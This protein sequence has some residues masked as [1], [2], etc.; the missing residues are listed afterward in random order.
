M[1][2]VASAVSFA[3]V[4]NVA[5]AG[6]VLH[7]YFDYI[8]S[9]AYLAWKVVPA[10]ARK[11]GYSFAPVPALFAGFLRTTGT[12]GPAEVPVKA[13]WMWKNNLRKAALMGVPLNIPAFHPFNPLLALRASCVQM[14]T[15][16]RERL[17]DALFDAVWVHGEHVSES[18]VVV[19]AAN[20]VGLDGAR[21]VADAHGEVAKTLL[22]GQT[23]RAI[24]AGAFGVPSMV[25]GGEVFWGYDDIPYLERFLAGKDP[26]VAAAVPGRA[27]QA[28]AIRRR[29]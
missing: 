11:Y 6:K 10:L 7:F 21:I 1:R 8:S 25:A 13:L 16:S 29:H 27:P 9:N 19:Q 18:A 12:L 3:E 5:D 28:S 22:R 14:E 23:D 20:S 24:A 4:V 2:N 17:V 26:L 15:E